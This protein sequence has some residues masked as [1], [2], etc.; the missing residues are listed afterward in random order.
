MQTLTD[1]I[2]MKAFFDYKAKIYSIFTAIFI[3]Y[4]KVFPQLPKRV[5]ACIQ[6]KEKH[7]TYKYYFLFYLY[8][9]ITKE[10]CKNL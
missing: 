5:V 7:Y 10:I 2:T 3:S 9:Q 6:K 4:V 1:D 8:V